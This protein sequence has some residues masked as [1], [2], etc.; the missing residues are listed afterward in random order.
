MSDRIDYTTIED[1]EVPGEVG[2]M[3]STR[4]SGDVLLGGHPESAPD[5]VME[6]FEQK[7][8]LVGASP[9]GSP[10]DVEMYGSGQ[11]DGQIA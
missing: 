9:D 11:D 8:G 6:Q 3:R 2:I 7:S 10:D 1:P 4:H 5:R